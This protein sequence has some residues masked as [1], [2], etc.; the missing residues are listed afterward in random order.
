MGPDDTD[1][2]IQICADYLG[3]RIP[4]TDLRDEPGPSKISIK[5][6]SV[7]F[8]GPVCEGNVGRGGYFFAVPLLK[9]RPEDT[10]DRVCELVFQCH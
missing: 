1:R 10:I 7:Q 8:Y 2:T 5:K 9:R 6:G 4:W 3:C